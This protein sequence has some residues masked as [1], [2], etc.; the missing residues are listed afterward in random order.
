MILL[1]TIISFGTD[2]S[3]RESLLLK[4]ITKYAGRFFF[5]FFKSFVDDIQLETR[6]I[7]ILHNVYF[8]YIF[9]N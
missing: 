5:C 8:E 7:N 2:Y 6:Q 1:I 3:V 4:T 9:S